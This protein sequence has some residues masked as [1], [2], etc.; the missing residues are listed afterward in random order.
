MSDS[1]AALT[2][3]AFIAE[4]EREWGELGEVIPGPM[5][6][7]AHREELAAA[8]TPLRLMWERFGFAG[9]AEGRFWICDPLV[10]REIAEMWT[11]GLDVGLPAQRWTPVFRSAF[12]DLILLGSTPGVLLWVGP[13]MGSFRL[14]NMSEQYDG[15]EGA[16]DEAAIMLLSGFDDT[17]FPAFDPNGVPLFEQCEMLLGPLTHETLYTFAPVPALGGEPWGPNA[18]I[19]QAAPHH[20]LLHSLQS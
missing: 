11:E 2:P 7:E 4:L 18:I 12:G 17:S 19:E 6:G 3:E 16:A 10:W 5:P 9:I 15:V 1:D 8:P 13:H 14:M 20:V